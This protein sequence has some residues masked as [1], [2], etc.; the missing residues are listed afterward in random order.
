MNVTTRTVQFSLIFFNR[1]APD[2]ESNNHLVYTWYWVG[3]GFL[4][5]LSAI[6]YSSYR[7]VYIL[8][9]RTQ[10]T[11][12]D[13][14]RRMSQKREKRICALVIWMNVAFCI[15]W[16]PYTIICFCYIL[17]GKEIVTPALV[18][19]PLLCAKATVCFNPILYI[20]MNPQ[21]ISS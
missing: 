4:A 13:A 14:V 18:V 6:L 20:A 2:W 8:R 19:V 7:T 16:M 3:V 10:M 12:S 9:E 21:V 5:P 1:C 15:G 17:G 11:R